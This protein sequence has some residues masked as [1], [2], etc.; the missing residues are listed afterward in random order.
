MK[1]SLFR[2]PCMTHTRWH[3]KPSRSTVIR[4]AV[5]AVLVGLI[6]T[7]ASGMLMPFVPIPKSQISVTGLPPP[8][9]TWRSLARWTG[10]LLYSLPNV[11]SL[12]E[13][14]P[15]DVE[16]EGEMPHRLIFR[17]YALR[18]EALIGSR[19]DG[20]DKPTFIDTGSFADAFPGWV[21][22]QRPSGSADERYFAF[23]SKAYGWPF[24]G[25]ALSRA[26]YRSP[27]AA[28]P[29]FQ[30]M[31]LVWNYELP[32]HPYWPGLLANT[33]IFATLIFL[34]IGPAR[35]HAIRPLRRTL[36]ER[37]GRCGVCK[38]PRPEPHT[39][40]PECGHTRGNA[41]HPKRSPGAHGT[42]AS[43]PISD[44]APPDAPSA[45]SATDE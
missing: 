24:R 43:G 42:R 16:E 7:V 25:M 14:E 11:S 30:N 23:D 13:S 15:F 6:F 19:Y 26:A 20:P 12:A 34:L 3:T 21:A 40:C 45:P 1:A 41:L 37:R 9:S 44:T 39:P 17:S 29:M 32:V 33:A 10:D 22:S 28:R 4:A 27:T 8:P 36:R 31:L 35:W 5:L 18:S 38:Y 2:D